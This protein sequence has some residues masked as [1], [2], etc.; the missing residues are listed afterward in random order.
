M[1]PN[2]PS[3]EGEERRSIRS[4]LGTPTMSLRAPSRSR[5]PRYFIAKPEARPEP[6]PT[7]MP[8]LTYSST[9]PSIPSAPVVDQNKQKAH[10]YNF[11]RLTVTFAAWRRSG[12]QATG[13]V[14]RAS[15]LGLRASPVGD[16]WRL[17]ATDRVIHGRRSARCG[18]PGGEAEKEALVMARAIC[19]ASRRN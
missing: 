14:A 12:A 15:S 7:T 5:R 4:H 17:A 6:N 1:K 8:L 2:M 16:E 19:V 10:F 11:C 18:A 3:N 9:C 13:A